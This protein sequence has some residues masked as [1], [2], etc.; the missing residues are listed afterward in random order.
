MPKLFV[1]ILD[2]KSSDE[3]VHREGLSDSD[4]DPLPPYILINEKYARVYLAKQP[5]ERISRSD[6]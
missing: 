3:G 4:D 1:T 2:I 5:A 6:S